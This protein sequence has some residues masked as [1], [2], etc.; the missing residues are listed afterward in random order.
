MRARREGA[1]EGL[2]D[3]ASAQAAAFAVAFEPFLAARV[4]ALYSPLRGEL[5]PICW[6][7]RPEAAGKTFVLPRT[8]PDRR[9]TFHLPTTIPIA[10]GTPGCTEHLVGS[11]IPG[12]FGI[13]EPVGPPI[14][15]SLIDLVVV[16][17]L[18]YDLRGSRL[19]YGGGY[20]DRW[21][22]QQRPELCAVGLGHDWQIVEALP[23]EDHD[24]PVAA[25]LTPTG[26]A[27]CA[28]R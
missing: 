28:A 13:L 19:G 10:P 6:L 2:I 4:V 18:A 15:S 27:P 11:L 25:I 9:L 20:Y 8:C 7:E 5:D 23:V 12:P 17:A 3:E 21:L 1:P 26:I 14:E 22:V 16:P 24:R